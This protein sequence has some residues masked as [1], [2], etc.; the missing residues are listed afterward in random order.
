MNSWVSVISGLSLC[1][2]FNQLSLENLHSNKLTYSLWNKYENGEIYGENE[3]MCLCFVSTPFHWVITSWFCLLKIHHL[4]NCVIVV[5]EHFYWLLNSAHTCH[6]LLVRNNER[7]I[8][9]LHSRCYR[10][11]EGTCHW[12]TSSFIAWPYMCMLI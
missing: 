3:P 5:C 11:T 6:K 1:N 2:I 9:Y 10:C 8:M 4:E 7:Q 12:R